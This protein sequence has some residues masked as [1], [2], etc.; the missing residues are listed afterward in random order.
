MRKIFVILSMGMMFSSC[1]TKKE[2]NET[3]SNLYDCKKKSEAQCQELSNVR[4][5]IALLQYDSAAAQKKIQNLI[6]DSIDKS[7]RLHQ[8]ELEIADLKG[9]N[10][11][12]S[13]KLT[14]TKSDAEIKKLLSDLQSTQEKLQKRE[15]ALAAAEK[16]LK[17]SSDQ[18][19]EKESKLKELS[20]IVSKQDSLMKNLRKKVADALRGYEGNGLEVVNKGGKVYVSLEEKLLFKSG[21]WD[22]DEKGVKALTKLSDFM[23]ENQD[24]NMVIEGHTDDRPYKGYGNINDNWDLSAKRATAIVRILLKNKKVNPACI[25]ATGRAEFVPLDNTQTAEARAKN[26]RIEIIL[27]PKMDELLEAMSNNAE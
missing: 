3:A 24:I 8:A 19:A 5:Q 2:F 20:N 13:D 14:N 12:L 16:N 23:A 11:K 22:V 15:D 9:L 17:I 6:S 1:V 7:K 25:S 18:M 26:R 21:S 27:S 4:K 10:Q